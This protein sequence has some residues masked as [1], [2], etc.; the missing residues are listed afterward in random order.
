MSKR[1]DPVSEKTKT[2][3]KI[4]KKANSDIKK[5]SEIVHDEVKDVQA[6]Y[7]I[8]FKYGKPQSSKKDKQSTKN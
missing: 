7:H 2:Q 6:K 4:S 5:F 8:S 3:K 1:L